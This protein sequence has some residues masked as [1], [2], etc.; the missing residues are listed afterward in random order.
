MQLVT[1][2]AESRFR[3]AFARLKAGK[4]EVLPYGT[5]VSQNNVA[6]EAGTDPTALKKARYPALIREIQAHVEI[7]GREIAAQKDRR[8]RHRQR[9]E[10]LATK[11]KNLQAQRDHAQGQLVS[12]HRRLLELLRENAAL[13][14]KIGEL[15]PPPSPLRR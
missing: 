1:E 9:R 11:S 10:D 7:S 8:V 6:K 5:P 12:A 4:P 13:K 2:T 14:V 15:M 3:E